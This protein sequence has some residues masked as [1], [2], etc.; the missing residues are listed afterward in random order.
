M[1]NQPSNIPPPRA[2]N[3]TRQLLMANSNRSSN[4]PTPSEGTSPAGLTIPGEESAGQRR[5]SYSTASPPVPNIPN[6]HY[7]S[8]AVLSQSYGARSL[9][10]RRASRGAAS[11]QDTP[12]NEEDEERVRVAVED[13]P[14]EKKA[15]I[16]RRHLV[17]REEREG[18]STPSRRPS[19]AAYG[20]IGQTE[21]DQFLDDVP[22]PVDEFE[23]F[24]IQFDN[25]GS[26]ITHGIYRWQSEAR[27][28]LKRP[29]SASF[30]HVR[31][32]SL[33]DPALEHIHQPNGMRRAYLAAKANARGEDQP[34]MV[35]NFIDF[36][37]L[38][39][40]FAGEDLDD[41]SEEDEE[42]ETLGAS[43]E[44]SVRESLLR[45][46]N[47]EDGLAYAADGTIPPSKATERSR[48]LRAH[49]LTRGGR[50]RSQ[51]V[52][53][54]GDATVT[55]AVLMLLKSFVGTGILF[56]G[57]AFFNGGI[58]FSSFVL[59]FI[60]LISLYSFL[61]LVKVRFVIPGGFGEMGGILYGPWMRN[62]ILSSIVLS[63]LGFVSAY[64]I[65]VA[66]NLK[67][68]VLAVTNCRT[69]VPI[70][71]LIFSEMLLFVPLALIRNLAKLSTTALVADVFILIGLVYIFGNEIASIA[72]NGMAH[73]ELFN[74]RDFPLLVGTAV[75]SFEGIGLV[76]PITESM[77]EPRK[78]PA[79]L[80][81]V[82]FFLMILFGGGGA[83]AYAAYGKDIQTV[84][85]INLPQD[86]KFVQVVQFIY[87]LAI[88]LSAPLQLFPALRI[89]ENAIFTRSGKQDPWVKWM[90]NGFRLCIVL[91]CTMV[92]WAGA[93]D[94]DK[95]VSLIGCFACVPL[96]Y[97]YP[98]MLHLKAVARSRWARVTDWML[99]I[100]GLAAAAYTTSQTVRLMFLPSGGTDFGHCSP[101]E[102][103]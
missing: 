91:L 53:R 99:I 50:G 20:A 24:P 93:A 44:D 21:R 1:A 39:G 79:V 23:P 34:M 95:F 10:E 43:A 38:F 82:M 61:L 47:V 45:G 25:E 5:A 94:L 69:D 62:L 63:Q 57:K 13:M 9:A 27:N 15:E 2:S 16:V 84:V 28:A 78:F 56:L 58:L 55:Q 90:K 70:Q 18:S 49:S 96:C 101:V 64:L 66:E 88:L 89:M 92:S 19:A 29:R 60:A 86:Q 75:F 103:V 37:L 33:A 83:L 41:I 11:G 30:S 98:A 102:R 40:H 4:A 6:P 81:G 67:A 87:A 80:S 68:F 65:F 8:P 31:R 14:K 97:V 12:R 77:R 35:N 74:P 85:I 100:F 26:D 32:K 17:S 72:S 7:G 36:L 52:V 76:I 3:L 51:S 42:V 71:Y 48:L 22:T 59:C 73:V 54:A 46:G